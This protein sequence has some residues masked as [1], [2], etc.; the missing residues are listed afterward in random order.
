MFD[1]FEKKGDF[2]M[3]LFRIL[4]TTQIIGNIIAV[5]TNFLMHG[6]TFPIVMNSIWV[7]VAI[8]IY[9]WVQKTGKVRIGIGS[10][11]GICAFVEFPML[12]FFI[13]RNALPYF[14]LPI[15]SIALIFEG[16]GRLVHFFA[17]YLYD[18]AI[19]I[20]MP[21]IS[22]FI[23]IDDVGKYNS[24]ICAFV[25]ATLSVFM[26][27]VLLSKQYEKN[28]EELFSKGQELQEQNVLLEKSESEA[29]EANMAKSKFLA[30]MSHEI[31][32]PING[33]IGMNEM[34]LRE[35][36][37]SEVQKYALDVQAASKNLLDLINEILDLS[38]I[39][40]GKMDILPVRYELHTLI[41]DMMNLLEIRAQDKNLSV[42][43][44]VDPGLPNGLYGDDLRI[45]QVLTNLLSNA[46]KYTKEGS[47][48][49]RI[50]GNIDGET[51]NMRVEVEDTGIGIKEEDMN[52]LFRP[53][54]RIEELRNRDIEG[55][56]L[57]INITTNLLHMMGSRLEVQSEYGKGS[58]FSFTLPQKIL[59]KS[60]IGKLG[61]RTIATE[62][63]QYTESF[64]A[65]NARILVVDDN[66]INRRVF[67]NLL[68]K[69]LVQITEAGS[70]EEALRLTEKN[71][72]D[73]IFLDH[74]M[75]DMDG[76]ETLHQL[77]ISPLNRCVD[78]PV[79]ALTA[80]AIAGAKEMYLSKGFDDY[81]TKPIASAKLEEMIRTY[82]P[83]ELL[84]ANF[85]DTFVRMEGNSA[86]DK[87]PEISG[88][89]WDYAK[90]RIED[91]EVLYTALESFFDNMPKWVKQLNSLYEE[92]AEEQQ[93]DSY[94]VLV[95]SIKG[96]AAMLGQMSI[97]NLSLLL[98]E[99]CAKG[100]LGR[101][102][103]LHPIFI[104]KLKECEEMN[105]NKIGIII[106]D[107][108]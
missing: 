18:I 55:T 1:F 49:L 66:D 42:E 72:Y 99:A 21:R 62:S 83:K 6:V 15:V 81:M 31:R 53:Y 67:R 59:D 105:R 46:V 27:V 40:A 19:M 75:M 38:K 104:E 108:L 101:I 89:D 64:V 2:T 84:D 11:I 36:K 77:R 14:L 60:P 58:T 86:I 78:V 51:L 80:N 69:T 106:R 16:R 37:T 82:L 23:Q 41:T 96:I 70:G 29:Q 76:I 63:H 56:G 34:I 4:A 94:R 26:M 12:Y 25:I 98:E 74:M 39:E 22:P 8:G 95:H 35:C 48:S 24:A 9:Y 45:R 85:D 13:E 61:V 65:P 7:V 103:F 3:R 91:E 28:N 97:W 107:S 68:K 57:G 10:L 79:I 44:E 90:I 47:V 33:I 52:G 92:L 93:V 73:I 43:V 20:W 88:F 102:Q 32:T 54:E 5:A 50:N 30:S 100:D 87:L 71:R 17:I